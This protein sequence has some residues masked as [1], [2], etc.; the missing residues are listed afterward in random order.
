MALAHISD[1]DSNLCCT[2]YAQPRSGDL[3]SPW[4]RI[5]ER[6]KL[7]EWWV[8]MKKGELA[9]LVEHD[10]I[11]RAG[12]FDS[13]STSDVAV[14][15]ASADGSDGEAGSDQDQASETEVLPPAETATA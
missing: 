15:A 10:T 1:T 2:V 13:A 14:I 12:D 6:T 3:V 5:I 7:H 11:H 9:S 8:A 4:F